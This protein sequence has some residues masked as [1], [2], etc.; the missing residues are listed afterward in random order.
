M[1][2]SHVFVTRGFRDRNIILRHNLTFVIH[3]MTLICN[4]GITLNEL[5][6]HISKCLNV[7]QGLK[8]KTDFH[9]KMS[10]CRHELG[11]ELPGNSN[12]ANM[13]L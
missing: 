7:A 12:T 4:V 2:K 10:V 1:R 8:Y 13:P 6:G 9:S 3:K 5:G 11:V